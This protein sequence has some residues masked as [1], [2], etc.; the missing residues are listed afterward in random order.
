LVARSCARPEITRAQAVKISIARLKKQ[1]FGASSE[2][3]VRKIEQLELAPESLE[4]TRAAADP[5]PEAD[6]PE[7]EDAPAT[8]S[9]G[10]D[11]V[12]PQRRRGK[13]PIADDAPRETIVL[14]PGERCPDCG[15]AARD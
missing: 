15:G 3:I 7:S 2:K 6:M 14:D 4:T 10:P 11:R 5:T 12:P 8:W 9:A 13:P 1:R